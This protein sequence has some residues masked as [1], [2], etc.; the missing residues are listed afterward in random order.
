MPLNS[1]R[2]DPYGLLCVLVLVRTHGLPGAALSSLTAASPVRPWNEVKSRR[3]APKRINTQGFACPNHQCLYSGITDAHIHALVGDGTHGRAERIQTFRCQ[4]C[5]TTFSARL[6]TPLY[7]LKTAS[8]QVAVVLTA[9]GSWAGSFGLRACLRLPASNNHYLADSRS[10][11]MLR[12]C[13]SVLSAISSFHISSWTNCAPGCAATHR[14]S[15]SGWLSILSQRL[16][17]C[18]SW[19][20][21][22]KMWRTWSSTPC[23]SSWP[24]VA[25]RSSPAMG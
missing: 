1:S 7:R 5:H 4:A 18:S 9:L 2:E 17:L 11:C 20:H 6:H 16:F 13:T 22:P 23:D 24:L 25:S 21:A 10:P 8:Q 3:G 15:G 19:V 12:P 14:C